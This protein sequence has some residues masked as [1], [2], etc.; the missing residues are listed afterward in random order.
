M[1]TISLETRDDRGEVLRLL[2]HLSPRARV[3]FL[4]WC[5]NNAPPGK[6]PPPTPMGYTR[7]IEEAH[8][9]DRADAKLTRMV[10]ADLLGLFSGWGLDPAAVAV[11][12]E[13]RVRS[14]HRT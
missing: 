5:A 14:S 9:C 4:V 7:A 11:T 13:R 8:R 12:L 3:G 6:L 1:T 10:F 2:G